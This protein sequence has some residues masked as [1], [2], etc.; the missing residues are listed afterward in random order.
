MSTPKLSIDPVAPPAAK[1][2]ASRVKR[3]S[4]PSPSRRP[5]LPT[6]ISYH[7]TPAG[8][9]YRIRI[10]SLK[11]L[12]ALGTDKPIDEIFDTLKLANQRLLKLTYEKDNVK[13]EFY[14]K[15]IAQLNAI[16]MEQL[17]KVHFEKYYSKQKSSKEHKSRMHV[18]SRTMIPVENP[19][20]FMFLNVSISMTD[21]NK[22][23]IPFGQIPVTEYKTHL[24]AFI[25]KRR[26]KVKNQT[27]INDLMFIH[28]AL[29]NANNYFRDI[30]KIYHPLEDVDFKTLKEQV[31]YVN[32]R[33]S[34]QDRMNIEKILI[35][36]SRKTHYHDMFIFL[37]ETGLRISEA[38]TILNKDIDWEKLTI[39]LA[40]KKS[41]TNERRH[42]GIT[43]RI[44]EVLEVRTKGLKLTDRIFPNSKDTY[45]TKLKNIKPYLDEL[46]IKFHWHMLRHTFISNTIDEKPIGALMH[47]VDINNF[48][49][50]QKNYLNPKESE[51]LAMKVAR[52]QQMTPDEIRRYVQHSDL[53]MTLG[54][55]T[56][57]QE[58]TKEEILMRKNEELQ[59][60]V[61]QMKKQLEERK[62]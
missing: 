37:H 43:P 17:F 38:L 32:K 14:E 52:S 9:K 51:K 22:N 40:S 18:I 8:L 35:E 1:G 11:K 23:E 6:G 41:E 31:T 4:V 10:R 45:Q 5:R 26:E 20:A 39:P 62:D 2:A 60:M 57:Q 59:A 50:F 7:H 24:I 53:Q 16:T 47:Q 54:T 12:Q 13:Q 56:H 44:R 46:G 36:K 61:L 28:T 34:K 30:P 42:I 49:H 19:R 33:L 58:P 48:Q 3:P 15:S 25:D 55:Y 29:K 27:I 21:F